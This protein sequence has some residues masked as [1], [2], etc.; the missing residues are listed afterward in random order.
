MSDIKNR[1][2]ALHESVLSAIEYR[3]GSEDVSPK[4]IELAMKFLKDNNV[5]VDF[6]APSVRAKLSVIPRM[7]ADELKLG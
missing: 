2:H 3:V 6:N 4:D 1:I 5:T 7:T